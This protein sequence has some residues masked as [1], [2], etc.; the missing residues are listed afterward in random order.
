MICTVY[1]LIVKH[2]GGLLKRLLDNQL[3]E[4]YY[5]KLKNEYVYHNYLILVY[6]N[7]IRCKIFNENSGIGK[8]YK[9]K[10]MSSIITLNHLIYTHCFINVYPSASLFH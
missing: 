8:H 2:L 6:I 7:F 10:N 9:F 3:F 5:F 1:R 4:L